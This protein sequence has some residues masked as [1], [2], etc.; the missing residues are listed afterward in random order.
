MPV[1]TASVKPAINVILDAL[2]LPIPATEAE[3]SAAILERFVRVVIV[4]K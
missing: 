4:R 2:N 3:M 1:I